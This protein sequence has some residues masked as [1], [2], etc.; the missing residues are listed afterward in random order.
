MVTTQQT[1]QT[2]TT[3]TVQPP[4]R[5]SP[6]RLDR[7]KEDECVRVCVCLRHKIVHLKI[8]RQ[9]LSIMYELRMY[10]SRQNVMWRLK[11]GVEN[12]KEFNTHANRLGACFLFVS[13]SR[14]ELEWRA[15]HRALLTVSISALDSADDSL[16]SSIRR[17][18]KK[19][20]NATCRDIR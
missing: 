11:G 17:I 20:N 8:C 16:P 7:V 1:Q 6:D 15:N 12:G 2:K 4:A 19:S 3:T 14:E 18:R 9:K 5:R 10:V 13:F